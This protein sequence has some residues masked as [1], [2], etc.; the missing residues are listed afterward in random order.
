MIEFLFRQVSP[1]YRLIKLEDD[2]PLFFRTLGYPFQISKS[3]LYA[4]GSPHSWPN[5]LAALA[6]LVD[7]FN[8]HE[9]TEEVEAQ[10]QGWISDYL[11]QSY[12]LFLQGN[13]EA[14]SALDEQMKERFLSCTEEAQLQT[15]QIAQ[16]I[17]EL[18]SK[19]QALKSEPSPLV[20]WETKKSMLLTDVGKFNTLIQNLTLHKGSLEKRAEQH[21]QQRD[22]KKVELEMNAAENQA[23]LQRVSEQTVNV[24]DFDK[25]TREFQRIEEDLQSA[26][27]F[28]KEKDK[29]TWDLE[30]LDSKKL[31]NLESLAMECNHAMKR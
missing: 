17:M 23:L 8:G 20:A 15:E 13:D 4:A 27:A 11:A 24:E 28:R 9:K 26:M 21:K 22:S 2:V 31:K 5:L 14:C 16:Q 18:D 12:A 25:M 19:L 7:L 10:S 29:E 1:K 30:V 3:A 6:W